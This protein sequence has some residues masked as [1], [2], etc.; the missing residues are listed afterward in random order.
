[1]TGQRSV[2]KATDSFPDGAAEASCM[3]QF[4][5]NSAPDR[6]MSAVSGAVLDDIYRWLMSN[7]FVILGTAQIDG[8]ASGAARIFQ[9]IKSNLSI[10]LSL[11]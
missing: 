10:V 7:G 6:K 3:R 9:Q 8:R 2:I 4:V 5:P 1:M 11:I